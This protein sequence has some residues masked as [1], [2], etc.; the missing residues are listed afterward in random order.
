MPVATSSGLKALQEELS[1]SRG[2]TTES[3]E[4]HKRQSSVNPLFRY[5]RTRTL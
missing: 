5:D 3:S 2:N 4:N 1:Q